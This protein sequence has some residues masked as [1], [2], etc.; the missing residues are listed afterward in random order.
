MKYDF[1]KGHTVVH[2]EPSVVVMV[3]ASASLVETWSA[4]DSELGKQ[5]KMR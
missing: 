4:D 5:G 2:D 3:L 1:V